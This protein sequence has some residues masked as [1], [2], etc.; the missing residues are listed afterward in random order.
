MGNY[1]LT[2]YLQ[3]NKLL[4]AKTHYI[5]SQEREKKKI[6]SFIPIIMLCKLLRSSNQ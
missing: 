1:Y 2:Y 4:S 6:R 3:I 5:F